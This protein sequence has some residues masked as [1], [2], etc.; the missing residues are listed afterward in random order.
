MKIHFNEHLTIK[1]ENSIIIQYYATGSI[2][3]HLSRIEEY[4]NRLMQS[5][6]SF[7][8]VKISEIESDI[9]KNFEQ[10]HFSISSYFRQKLITQNR[11]L[12]AKL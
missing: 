1:R 10:I 12:K 6:E 3:D 4:L 5:K 2:F 11:P 9:I 7:L 8:Q